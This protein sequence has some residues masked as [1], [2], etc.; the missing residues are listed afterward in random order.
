[1]AVSHYMRDTNFVPINRPTGM[2]RISSDKSQQIISGDTRVYTITFLYSL[3]FYLSLGFSPSPYICI[4][5]CVCIYLSFTHE[6]TIFS[7][8]GE[9][10][11]LL[12]STFMWQ[13]VQLFWSHS[14][15]F[16][17]MWQKVYS[18]NKIGHMFTCIVPCLILK[19]TI[20]QFY[21]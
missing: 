12:K 8:K 9:K 7:K 16:T 15:P 18:N 10:T 13:C 2:S 5:C 1:M 11:L 4:G 14:D 20:H 6:G 3:I 21:Y 17:Y 19:A